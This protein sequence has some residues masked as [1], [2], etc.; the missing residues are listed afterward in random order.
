MRFAFP[1]LLV[2]T[3]LAFAAPV[4]EKPAPP[5][6]PAPR[7]VVAESRGDSILITSY[8]QVPVIEERTVVSKEGNVVVEKKVTVTVM[9]TVPVQRMLPGAAVKVYDADAEHSCRPPTPSP[10]SRNRRRCCSPRMAN[11]S[12]RPT[13]P[14]SIRKC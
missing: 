7:F 14:C 9:R 8:E 11:S 3:G 1:T 10:V 13:G 6:G 5:S 2:C 4:P 12:T